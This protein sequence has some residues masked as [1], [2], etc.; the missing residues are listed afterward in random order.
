MQDDQGHSDHSQAAERGP[1]LGRG[2]KGDYS[3]SPRSV[4][5]CSSLRSL[6]VLNNSFIVP[7]QPAKPK[8]VDRVTR[9]RSATMA[10]ETGAL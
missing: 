5:G 3:P 6:P 8:K 1:G 9:F 4:L 7:A 10:R 2:S